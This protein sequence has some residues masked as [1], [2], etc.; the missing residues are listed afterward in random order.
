MN[1][2]SSSSRSAFTLI[3]LLTVIAII[4]ILASILIP[5]LSAV[6]ESAR[7]AHCVSNLRQLGMGMIAAIGDNNDRFIN[8]PRNPGSGDGNWPWNPIIALMV[9]LDPYLDKGV[10]V[11]EFPGNATAEHAFGVWRCP[12]TEATRFLQWPYYPSGWLWSGSS[13][14][15]LALGR[16]VASIHVELTRFPMIGDRGSDNLAT[17]GTGNFGTWSLGNSGAA[18]FNPHRGWHANDRLNIVFADGSVRGYTYIRGEP[19]ELTD[20]LTAAQPN[21]WP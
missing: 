16:P 1:H 6:R 19:G 2:Q 8:L 4:G 11:G 21:N 12:G 15:Y 17:G 10:A 9:S 5:T 14:E 13:S 3:E 20:I 18:G 7:N